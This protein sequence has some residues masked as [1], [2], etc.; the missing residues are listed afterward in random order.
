MIDT[1]M[2]RADPLGQHLH[3]PTE[4]LEKK[5]QYTQDSDMYGLGIIMIEFWYQKDVFQNVG[6]PRKLFAMSMH[7][8]PNCEPH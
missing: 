1:A 3:I 6:K 4:V 5:E 7:V 2:E 8:L